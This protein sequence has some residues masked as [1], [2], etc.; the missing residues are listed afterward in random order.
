MSFKVNYKGLEVTV[1]SIDDLD[2][3][4]ERATGTTGNARTNG[5]SRSPVLPRDEPTISAFVASLSENARHGL[6]VLIDHGGVMRDRDFCRALNIPDNTALGG[7]VTSP[8][9]RAANRAGV[10]ADT[11]LVKRQISDNPRVFE[12]SVPTQNVEAV[13][14]GLRG[15]DE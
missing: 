1:D 7:R 2:H 14:M 5:H 15:A 11:V 8:I 4:A 3:L 9:Q 12:Y 13:S 6:S 10:Q